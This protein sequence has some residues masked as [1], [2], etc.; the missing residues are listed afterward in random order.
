M[1]Q[2]TYTILFLC[3][4]MLCISFEAQA[5]HGRWSSELSATQKEHAQDIIRKASPEIE[6]MRVD[7]LEKIQELHNFTYTSSEDHQTLAKLGQ[8]LQQQRQALRKKLRALDKQLLEEVGVSLQ[9]YRGRDCNDL[10]QTSVAQE[11]N[12]EKHT[13]DPP[14]HT[15]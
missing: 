9:G 10:C 13:M 14:H 15:E 8:E 7:M 4:Y 12:L 2:H 6:A 5:K 1:R 3:A 11:S